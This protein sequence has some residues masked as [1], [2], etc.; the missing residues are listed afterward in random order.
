[1]LFAV[2]ISQISLPTSLKATGTW[3][4]LSTEMRS[5]TRYMNGS[6][7]YL[8]GDTCLDREK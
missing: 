4:E 5:G 2:V 8:N 6:G 7:S 1:M 3:K